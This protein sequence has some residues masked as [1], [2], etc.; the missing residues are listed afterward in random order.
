MSHTDDHNS[1]PDCDPNALVDNISEQLMDRVAG[2]YFRPISRQAVFCSPGDYNDLHHIDDDTLVTIYADKLPDV[3]LYDDQAVPDGDPRVLPKSIEDFRRGARLQDLLTDRHAR[4]I[5]EQFGT[6]DI[7]R[8][9]KP[10][11]ERVRASVEVP[12]EVLSEQVELDQET[13]NEHHLQVAVSEF[14]RSFDRGECVRPIQFTAEHELTSTPDK[15]TDATLEPFDRPMIGEAYMQL[16]RKLAASIGEKIGESASLPITGEKE[17]IIEP[18]N[19]PTAFNEERYDD[20]GDPVDY[21]T[22]TEIVRCGERLLD[23]GRIY[24]PDPSGA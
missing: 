1:D 22:E 12:F 20:W 16:R 24:I 11:A 18:E 2:D 5:V 3:E 19:P 14:E 10:G 17:V 6:I 7:D 4:E 21:Q 8:N 23:L 9:D 15:L 13:I